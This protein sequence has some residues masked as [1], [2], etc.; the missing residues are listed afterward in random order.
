MLA[1]LVDGN[2]FITICDSLR[3]PSML[4]SVTKTVVNSQQLHQSQCTLQEML[5]VH[6]TNDV[7]SFVLLQSTIR[8]L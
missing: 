1:K 8:K 2:V 4:H 7:P 5:A 3:E 6:L